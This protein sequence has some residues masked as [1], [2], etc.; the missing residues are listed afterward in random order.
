MILFIIAILYGLFKFFSEN[1]EKTAM[2]IYAKIIFNFAYKTLILY[3]MI[4]CSFAG[5]NKQI[6]SQFS[7]RYALEFLKKLMK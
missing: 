3:P 7:D 4:W 6:K 2:P 1:R 5:L